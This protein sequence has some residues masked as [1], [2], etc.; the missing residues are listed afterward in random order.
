MR[1]LYQKQEDICASLEKQLRV[2][3]ICA[4]SFSELETSEKKFCTQYFKTNVAP[5]LSPQI[6]DTH[7]PFPHLRN[8]VLH[9]GAWVKYKSR[10]VFAVCLL[11]TSRC[12]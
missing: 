11:Y 3:G 2:H 7:H 4:L 8:K 9:I 6:V 12:V 1:R 10:E 5:I